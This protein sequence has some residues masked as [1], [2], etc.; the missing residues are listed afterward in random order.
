MKT[1]VD[2]MSDSQPGKPS[3]QRDRWKM[4]ASL[5]GAAVPEEP[6]EADVPEAAATE[7]SSQTTLP[8]ADKPA[9]PSAER[10]K[11]K[12][13][14][15]ARAPRDWNALCGQL[16]IEVS[17]D[18]AVREEPQPPAIVWQKPI[19]W[20][21]PR[22][23]APV[24]DESAERDPALSFFDP[25][26]ALEVDTV[27]AELDVPPAL[28]AEIDAAASE[29]EVDSE[30]A[31]DRAPIASGD[32]TTGRRRRRRRRRRGAPE[33]EETADADELAAT[34]ARIDDEDESDESPVSAEDEDAGEEREE[35][36]SSERGRRPRRR[37]RR[38]ARREEV[39]AEIETEADDTVDE[40]DEDDDE[41]D[42]VIIDHYDDDDDDDEVES[43]I[44]HGRGGSRSAPGD[45]ARR[46]GEGT[47][48]GKHKK[49]PTWEEAMAVIVS[50]NMESRRRDGNTGKS[51]PRGPRRRGRGPNDRR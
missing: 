45:E 17:P 20:S 3:D 2:R 35:S 24:R 7:S 8:A 30:S 9:S 34:D 38:P 39:R 40:S 31:D 15:P 12:P 1:Q 21:P 44:R 13:A 18:P 46:G 22:E 41:E 50:A 48:R 10:P 49:I 29:E 27:D 26:A 11:A 42:D 25:D 36:T 6:A 19:E 14:Q 33:R 5:L 4:I 47:G 51:R 32:A 23:P 28:E 37:R 16:G 43:S